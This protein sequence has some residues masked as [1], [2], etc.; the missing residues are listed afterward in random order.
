MA[1]PVSHWIG[2]NP[3]LKATASGLPCESVEAIEYLCDAIR[4]G[5]VR[6]RF[7]NEDTIPASQWH[8][9]DHGRSLETENGRY[10]GEA[11]INR[12]DLFKWLKRQ[13]P[14]TSKAGRKW[15]H[16]W[17]GAWIEVCWLIYQEGNLPPKQSEIEN[18]MAEYFVDSGVDE[19][20]ERTIRDYVSR[21][22]QVWVD[23]GKGR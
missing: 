4:D 12:A 17:H 20:G 22:Y 13:E 7:P 8:V 16:D 9:L 21:L 11:E 2:L 18:L 23:K 6:T 15:K 14:R 10:I 5:H 1:I 19:P 3:A